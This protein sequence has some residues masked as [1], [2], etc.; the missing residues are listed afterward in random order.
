MLVA[1]VTIGERAVT[2][3]GSAIAKDVPAGAL[4]I[5]RTEQRNVEGWADR[6]AA[7]E[8]TDTQG[9]GTQS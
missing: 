1:P 4:G 3:A 2:G 6:R 9:S 5:E 8:T 7:R